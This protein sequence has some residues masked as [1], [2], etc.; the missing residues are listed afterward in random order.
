MLNGLSNS[1]IAALG[2]S[3]FNKP[4]IRSPKGA[5][6]LNTAVRNWRVLRKMMSEI[7]IKITW[8]PKVNA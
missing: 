4:H 5:N 7:R 8:T 3:K 1:L 2:I 6:K